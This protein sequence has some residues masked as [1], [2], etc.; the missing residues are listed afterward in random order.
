MLLN[1]FLSMSE[2]AVVS[3]RKPRLQHMADEG[4][5]GARTALRL[6]QNSNDFL[7]SIQVGI[8]LIGVL[9]G[10]FSG[11]TLSEKLA[12]MLMQI[13]PRIEPYADGLALG[14][15]VMSVS[16]LSLVVG[17]LV[18]KRLALNNPE[19]IAVRVSKVIWLIGLVLKP[20]VMILSMSS[21]L[22]LRLF[23]AHI[24]KDEVVTEEEVKI[25]IEQGAKSGVF[26][27]HEEQMMKQIL[28]LDDSRVLDAMTPRTDVVCLDLNESPDINLKIVAEKKHSYFPVYDDSIDDVIG[29][30][31]VKE[32]LSVLLDGREI[33]IKDCV[34]P[35]LFLP[36]SIT[37][38]V[39]LEKLKRTGEHIAIALDEY[40]GFAGVVTIHDI[41]ESIFGH[42]PDKHSDD[43]AMVV[44]REDGSFLIDGRFPFDDF[45]EMF[46]IK[47]SKSFEADFQTV[48]GF[49]MAKL[50]KVPK[51]GNIFKLKNYAVEVVDMD[52][53][54][55]DKILVTKR[56]KP[57]A[58]AKT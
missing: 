9:A 4:K 28:K 45:V 35:A 54:R 19:A 56:K 51:E 37:L 23:G 48:G 39:A 31:S 6:S 53:N 41:T 12:A 24:V 8:T 36:E 16:Y 15:V 58:K 13:S 14:V 11:A 46:K 57:S 2:M 5:L 50:G 55:V 29:L 34:K 49:V 21:S 7:A 20:I 3:S 22:I 42:L 26:D 44:K 25:L 38:D 10:A 32:L 43:D 40:G 52:R 30:L 1:G 33:I 18:P 27:K 47:F 17:E